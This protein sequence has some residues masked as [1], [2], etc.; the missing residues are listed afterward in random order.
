MRNRLYE[1]EIAPIA[2]PDGLLTSGKK[3]QVS[4]SAVSIQAGGREDYLLVK[5]QSGQVVFFAPAVS[6]ISCH[7]EYLNTSENSL[8]VFK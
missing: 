1:I 3:L 2:L 4:G 7:I 8:K 5:D 6:I